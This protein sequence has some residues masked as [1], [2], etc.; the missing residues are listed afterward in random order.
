MRTEKTALALAIIALVMGWPPAHAQEGCSRVVVYTLP[1]V[2]WEDLARHRP[3]AVWAAIDEGAMGSMSVRTNRSRT[4]YA[5]GFATIG[6][7]SRLDGGETTGGPADPDEIAARDVLVRSNVTAA[8]LDEMKE[9]ADRAGYKAAP[10]ALG[11]AL[12]SIETIAIGNAEA[13][14]PPPVVIG[15]QRWPLLAAMDEA[16]IVDLA[17]TGPALLETTP[18]GLA[19]TGDE[20]LLAVSGVLEQRCSVSV[21]D[22]GDLIRA[23]QGTLAPEAAVDAARASA[24]AD[25]DVLLGAIRASLDP[26][27]DLLLIVSPTSPLEEDQA[28]FGVAI[29]VGP[30]FP[31]GTMLTSATTRRAGIVTLPDIA[32][33]VLAHQRL[34]RPAPMLGRPFYATASSEDRLGAAIE[35]DDESTFVDR[36]RPGIWT[37][38]VVLQL[39]VY[40]VIAYYLW[41]RARSA[42]RVPNRPVL[43]AAA[44]WLLAFPV[45]TF[46]LGAISGHVLGVAGYSAALVALAAGIVAVVRWRWRDPLDRVL[47]VAALTSVVLLGDLV[48]GSTLQLNT[49]FSYSP[50]VA[51]RFTGIGNIGFAVLGAA[52][53]LTGALAVRKVASR[54]VAL[55]IVGGLFIV[56][57]VID[58]APAFGSDVGGTLSLV[59]ALGLTWLLLEGRRPGWRALVVAAVGTA[60]AVAGFLAWDLSLPEESRTHLGRLL[61]DVRARGSD[62]L[63]ETV[64]RK[65]RANFRVFTSTI[66]TY[67]VPPL[68][69]FVGWLLSRPAGRWKDVAA[70]YPA[71]RAGI[72]GGLI[73]AVLGF[74]VNDSGIVVP[75]VILSMLVPAALIVHLMLEQETSR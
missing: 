14:E 60:V 18:S 8:G 41:R 45:A 4:D 57:I 70:R 39:A 10:G 36:I 17:A 47:A 25:A 74:A 58:G 29:A 28:H 35:L 5:S 75:A 72:I 33:T 59:P 48:L 34:D 24:L 56:T 19:R 52:V 3:P 69:L 42:S 53:I 63:F 11:S 16:G 12:G 61:E 68:L 66:W 64:A 22:H 37:A 49:V 71:F 1:G 51:G 7:G 9:L 15:Y 38:Y 6:G 73:L 21:I 31:P 26:R 44:L 54:R 2:T 62:V 43:E 55:G 46:L 50:I 27:R 13:Y 23:E 20:I 40:G 30:G 65:L 67:L 32:P